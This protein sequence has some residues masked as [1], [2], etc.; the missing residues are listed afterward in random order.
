MRQDQI[1][2]ALW[3]QADD[4]KDKLFALVAKV[5]A[6][7]AKRGAVQPSQD[8]RSCR[9][10]DVLRQIQDTA[11]HW[12]T[13]T[14]R[15]SLAMGYIDKVGR[16][17]AVFQDWLN[18]L[19]SGDYGS[20]V[21][22]V[23]KLVIGAAGQYVKVEEATFSALAE[24]PDIIRGAQSY[25]KVY[26]DR[27]DQALEKKTF[28]LFLSILKA[29][30]H[31]MQFFADS[32]LK[33]IRK[34]AA[35]IKEEA[36]RCL[37]WAVHDQGLVIKN[38]DKKSDTGLDLLENMYRMLDGKYFVSRDTGS[39][40]ET[41]KRLRKTI[42]YDPNVLETD[43]KKSVMA[44]E[45]LDER[46]KARAATMI[47]NSN[48]KSRMV[49]T[50]ASTCL[51]VNGRADLAAANGVS[52]LTYVA[53]SLVQASRDTGSIF[54]MAYFCDFHRPSY[55][56]STEASAVGILVS[57]LGQLLSQMEQRGL[58]M[59][60]SF[61]D[62][63]DWRHLESLQLDI[64]W[65]VLR[66]LISQ[67]PEGS[68]L[69]CVIDEISRYESS[70]LE[71]DTEQIIRR[72][73][74]LVKNSQNIVFKLLLTCHGRALSVFPYFEGCTIDLASHME[75]EDSSTWWMRSAQHQSA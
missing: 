6:K 17:S 20:S 64:L 9:W 43:L 62:A 15:S 65:K 52:P 39:S 72:L 74:R 47:R 69:V 46:E 13:S 10:E 4:E 27:R 36:D 18:L 29:L 26:A 22:G 32:V 42:R 50:S 71:Q 41:V 60:L 28:D 16:N 25:V 1:S 40:S 35:R 19:P 66:Q 53:G 61:L 3:E 70:A 23:F 68:V 37:A 11:S 58:H 7:L 30:T 21:C 55:E 54:L 12:S 2:A 75:P 49:E 73:T 31:I 33:E 59:D 67:L 51:L 63:R 5:Q 34:Q 38:M 14:H 45:R 44:G 57:F 48:Y 56:W 8:I 24:I